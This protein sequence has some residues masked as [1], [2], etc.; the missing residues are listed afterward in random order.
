M[1]ARRTY[2]KPA[3]RGRQRGFLLNPFRFGGGAGGVFNYADFLNGKGGDAWLADS[4]HYI[5]AGRAGPATVGSKIA[6]LS[7][8][9]G[10]YNAAQSSAD[11]QPTLAEDAS[12]KYIRFDGA[13]GMMA[14]TNAD[15]RYLHDSASNAYLCAAMRFGTV[16]DP[17]TGYII[18]STYSGVT[19]AYGA[20]FF[21]EDRLDVSANNALRALISR[22]IN[23]SPA[24]DL[25]S[26]SEQLTPAV[27]VIVE[28]VK[29]SS[30]IAMYVNGVL[31]SSGAL[32]SASSVNSSSGL[33]I[34]CLSGGA[35]GLVGRV[36]GL[37]ICNSVPSSGQRAAIQADMSARCVSAPI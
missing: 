6:S 20:A 22:G 28:V 2:V 14:G 24:I 1:I 26:P 36:Y 4:T 16:V 8:S 5:D 19:T 17:N 32:V 34:G 21:Y 15:W 29:Q 31:I 7:G 23:A 11:M 35:L 33:W 27:D 10:F 9:A 25:Q 18:V 12:K 3:L 30:N 37:L 13:G